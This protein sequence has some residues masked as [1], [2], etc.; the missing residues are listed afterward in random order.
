MPAWDFAYYGI[1]PHWTAELVLLTAQAPKKGL[2]VCNTTV[3]YQW[4]CA[5]SEVKQCRCTKECVHQVIKVPRLEH[6]MMI[7][8]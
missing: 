3:T 7:D 1:E 6:I 4:I 2:Q 8:C 5:H